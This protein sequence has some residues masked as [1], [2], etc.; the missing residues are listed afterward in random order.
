VRPVSFLIFDPGGV[1]Y[2]VEPMVDIIA[3]SQVLASFGPLAQ[4]QVFISR[5]KE[6]V[7]FS[8]WFHGSMSSQQAV[9]RLVP[10]GICF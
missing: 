7:F 5:I 1:D 9:T 2:G 4:F 3:F 8:P 10:Y 6:L